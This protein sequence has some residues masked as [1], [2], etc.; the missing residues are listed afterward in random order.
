MNHAITVK[1]V[2]ELVGGGVV[3]TV[4]VVLAVALL[5]AY[6]SGFKH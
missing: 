6:G 5:S 3:V 4:V 1:D 2:L